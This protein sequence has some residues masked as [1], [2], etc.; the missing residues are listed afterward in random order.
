[1]RQLLQTA[2]NVG[3]ACGRVDAEKLIPDPTTVARCIAS[4]AKV[5]RQQVTIE[6]LPYIE[7]NLASATT[8]NWTNHVQEHYM[9]ITLHYITK[10]WILM[11]RILV[12]IN[13]GTDDEKLTAERL[14]SEILLKLQQRGVFPHLARK[15][16]WVSDNGPDVKKALE[17]WEERLYCASHALNVSLRNSISVKYHLLVSKALEAY[18]EAK[19]IIDAGN[20][21]TREAREQLP[22]KHRLRQRLRVSNSQSQSHYAMLMLWHDFRDEESILF[23]THPRQLLQIFQ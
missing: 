8:D 18:P 16:V 22:P 1:M 4:E 15:L 13:V 20:S 11:R 21:W 14:R 17:W 7:D 6:I 12:M 19:R 23:E 3:A 2:V 9:T 10:F 5:A